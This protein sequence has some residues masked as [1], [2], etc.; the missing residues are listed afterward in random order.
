MN[1]SPLINKKFFNRV[2]PYYDKGIFNKWMTAKLI[3]ML[4]EVKLVKNSAI[5]DAG[6]GT[7]NLLKLLSNQNKNFNLYGIDISREMLK[8]AGKKLEKGIILR[9]ESIE[10]AK[11]KNNFFDYVFSTEAFHHYS[12]YD[13]V[14]KKIYGILNKNGR[15]IILDLNFGFILNSLFHLIE[16][17]NNKMHSK[18]DFRNLFKQYGFK[19]IKQK[20]I[21][22]FFILT[23]GEKYEKPLST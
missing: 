22:L 6:C 20:D 18:K 19:V 17:G 3:E 1:S 15:L 23:I 2:A 5:L 8:I 9:L 14:M 13:R 12:N 10:N 21:G 16:P 4:Q 11:F 7:G